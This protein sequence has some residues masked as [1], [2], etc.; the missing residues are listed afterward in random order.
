M[1]RFVAEVNQVR[2]AREHLD[3]ISENGRSV[4]RATLIRRRRRI[5][6]IEVEVVKPEVETP[7][8]VNDPVK[9][10]LDPPKPRKQPQFGTKPPSPQM[11]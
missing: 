11:A 9:S 2:N 4:M 5:R 1:A 8:G 3:V 7:P 6:V 10:D